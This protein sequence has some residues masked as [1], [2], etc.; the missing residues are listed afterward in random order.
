[1]SC[2]DPHRQTSGAQIGDGGTGSSGEGSGDSSRDGEVVLTALCSTSHRIL[3]ADLEQL[4][5]LEPA[6]LG[7]VLLALG[8][9][10]SLGHV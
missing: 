4:H 1:M 8:V 3:A 6:L 9:S 2:R 10:G 7:A 5:H